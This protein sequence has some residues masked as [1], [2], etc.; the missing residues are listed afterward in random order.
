MS[1][2]YDEFLAELK[3]SHNT[4]VKTAIARLYELLK[5]EDPNLSKDDM[6]ER[7][8]KDCLEIWRKETIQKFMPE[9]LKDKERQ[10]AG[11]SGRKKQLISVTTDGNVAG[12]N[13]AENEPESEKESEPSS[14]HQQQ[15]QQQQQ[16]TTNVD[17]EQEKKD[18][19]EKSHNGN[20]IY[21]TNE[22]AKQEARI[23]TLRLE[24]GRL[25][26]RLKEQEG[27]INELV[28]SVNAAASLKPNNTKVPPVKDS[29]DYK[30]L[31]SE[32]Y[33][34][35][36]ERDELKQ[37]ASNQIKEHPERTFQ[38][39]SSMT[40]VESLAS[41]V[42]AKLNGEVE[43]P[44]VDTSAFFL[45]CRNAKQVMYLKVENSRVKSWESDFRRAKKQ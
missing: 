22:D 2:R 16:Q 42:G 35:R 6:Y 10:E 7:I 44:A 25:Q 32:L 17:Y 18:L 20:S 43:F 23:E 31:E 33:M 38:N 40:P 27:Q 24:N 14:F 5:E 37:I 26:E 3:N 28:K 30:A 1:N 11:R 12:I 13:R 34:V 36:Q 15:H 8:M 39:A 19:Y 41:A 9:D 4:T 21:Y 45:D 29:L